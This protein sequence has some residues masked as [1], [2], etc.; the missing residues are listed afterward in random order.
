MHRFEKNLE[1]MKNINYI[2]KERGAVFVMTA[3]LLPILFGFM[4]LAYDVGNLYMH[5]ARLQNVA[6]S[7]ALAGARA[8][9]E[10]GE[11]LMGIR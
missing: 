5:K 4:G 7:A 10:N 3:L 9:V 6:D 1:M 11:K 8:F 2:Q